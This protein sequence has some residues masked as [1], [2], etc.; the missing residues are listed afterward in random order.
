MVR[1]HPGA[2]WHDSACLNRQK[3]KSIRAHTHTSKVRRQHKH[4]WH[5]CPRL[6]VFAYECRRHRD[7]RFSRSKLD[8]CRTFCLLL[9]MTDARIGMAGQIQTLTQLAAI[10]SQCYYSKWHYGGMCGCKTCW[11]AAGD[12]SVCLCVCVCVCVQVLMSELGA[13]GFNIEWVY[14]AN[15]NS[16]SWL[17]QMVLGPDVSTGRERES[18][19]WTHSV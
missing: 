3:R 1:V 2:R 7:K 6:R 18:K 15:G 8:S 12:V 14:R 11:C 9:K 13:A 4:L 5:Y 17:R 16:G 19:R 10:C